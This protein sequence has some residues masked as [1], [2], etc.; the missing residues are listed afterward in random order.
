MKLRSAVALGPLAFAISVLAGDK[1][2]DLSSMRAGD[3]VG[4]ALAEL[5]AQGFRVVYS[6]AL[7]KPTMTLHVA[8][9]ASRIEE[10]LPQILTPSMLTSRAQVARR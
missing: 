3:T 8:P 6:S 2:V 4:W 7:V 9:T 5:N 10:L 1:R